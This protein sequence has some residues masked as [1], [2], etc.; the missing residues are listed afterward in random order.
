M[1]V[2]REK[3]QENGERLI[4]AFVDEVRARGYDAVSLRDVARAAG[5]SDG[6]IYKHFPSKEKILLAYYALR[7]D[8]L[9]G[10][11]AELAARPG[12]SFAERMHALLEFQIGQYEGD[13]DFLAKTF[14]PTFISASLMWGEVAA[15]RKIYVD[16]V[17]G[18]LAAA[19]SRGEIPALAL[20][21]VVEEMIWCHYVTVMLYW[22][23]DRSDRHDDTTQFIDRT[24]NLFA[25]VVGGPLLP[26]AQ[27]LVGFLVNR[28]LMPLLMELGGMKPG[29]PWSGN[30]FGS[31]GDAG[32]EAAGPGESGP[33]AKAGKAGK[34]AERPDAR[35][36]KPSKPA[37]TK[38]R[39]AAKP[40]PGAAHNARAARTRANRKGAR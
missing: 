2:S 3:K 24:L 9:K 19:E 23:R 35:D 8:R 5:M 16:T 15:M 32:A 31:S 4:E 17:R 14:R 34:D 21:Y 33:V 7:M 40:K 39:N 27:D 37:G 25:A 1:R 12:Y 20:P 28:H 30:P 36:R 22:Q 26:M 11:G 13:K 38:A 29:A 18:F 6:A 10:H